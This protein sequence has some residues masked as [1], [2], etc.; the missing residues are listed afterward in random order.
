MPYVIRTFIVKPE[1]SSRVGGPAKEAM[2]ERGLLT[3]YN[4]LAAG[5]AL[6]DLVRYPH[7]TDAHQGLVLEV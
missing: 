6:T 1:L 4:D 3:N 2:M 7:L 5:L